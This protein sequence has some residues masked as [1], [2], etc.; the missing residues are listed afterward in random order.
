[1]RDNVDESRCQRTACRPSSSSFLEFR[2]T[3]C[4]SARARKDGNNWKKSTANARGPVPHRATQLQPATTPHTTPLTTYE[5]PRFHHP[6]RQTAGILTQ[7]FEDERVVAPRKEARRKG[8]RGLSGWKRKT[9]SWRTK[10]SKPASRKPS[11][12]RPKSSCSSSTSGSSTRALALARPPRARS[13]SSTPALS[14]VP[15]S[16]SSALTRG[17]KL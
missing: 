13:S 14:K 3:W 11:Q 9:S 12:T 15:R 1:M 10:H 7:V 6:C 2:S 5:R 17:C 16:F 4:P 8:G